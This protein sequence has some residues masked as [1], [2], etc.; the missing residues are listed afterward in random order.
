MLHF[1]IFL[2]P[3]APGL[4]SDQKARRLLFCP[5]GKQAVV[6]KE[7]RPFSTGSGPPVSLLS[8]CFV[9][10]GI[11]QLGLR[12][13][14]PSSFRVTAGWR[15]KGLP[16]TEPELSFPN[17]GNDDRS[18]TDHVSRAEPY[19]ERQA[20]LGVIIKDNTDTCFSS[21]GAGCLIFSH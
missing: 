12:K 14:A 5:V 19:G 13:Q 18:V 4:I 3:G 15:G 6:E 21:Q 8:G 11:S 16:R 17:E 7:S 1:S 10:R 2:A 20:A 9:E